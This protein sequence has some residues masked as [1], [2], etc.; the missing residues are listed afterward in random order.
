[1]P[2]FLPLI[3]MAGAATIS[4]AEFEQLSP[5][6]AGDIILAGQDHAPIVAIERP[7]RG[8]LTPPNMV[9]YLLVEQPVRVDGG[10][11]RRR[12]YVSFIHPPERPRGEAK[13]SD[14]AAGREI[15]LA[16][17]GI[18]PSGQYVRIN[19]NLDQGTA[20][21]GLT[22]LQQ[23]RAGERRFTP[24]CAD[25]T[26]SGLCDNVETIT[27][28]LAREEPWL[29]QIARGSLRFTLGQNGVV[30]HVYLNPA[31]PDQVVVEREVPPPA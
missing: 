18:C 24:E 16:P 6:T 25:R 19:F 14:P 2:S 15:A 13:A 17:R 23:I 1:M 5:G 11:T 7:A 21:E 20:F 4:L 3:F 27:R 31:S 9:Q 10:C 29:V 22:L 30:T 28:E 12:W 8:G 26:H